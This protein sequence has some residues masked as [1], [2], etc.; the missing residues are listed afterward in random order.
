M[1]WGQSIFSEVN[2]EF[3][4]NPYPA[5]GETIAVRLRVLK[6]APVE[7]VLLRDIRDGV[8]RRRA[9]QLVHRDGMFA[10]YALDLTV[11]SPRVQYSFELKTDTGY[12]FYTRRR[13]TRF[14]QT[15][16]AD[17][18][19]LADM[20]NPDWVPGAVF[21]QIFP[22]RFRRGDHYGQHAVADGEYVFDG[23]STQA[24]Q[25]GA[26]PPEFS[27]G[28]CL[29]FFN[30]DLDGVTEAISYL[31]DLG[32]TAIYLNPIFSAKTNHRYDCIDYFSVDPHL[33]GDDAFIRLLDAL[34]REGMRCIVDVSINHT[35]KDHPWFL[36][37]SAA[38]G[39]AE[40]DFYY[41]QSDAS[42]FIYWMDIP[43]LPQ[44]NY[45]SSELRRIIWEGRDSLVRRYLDPPYSMDGWR[46]DVAN[47]V[48]RCGRDQ[49]C[50]EIWQGVRRAVKAT[51]PKAYI[52]GEHWEDHIDYVLGDQ[53][54]GAMNYFG[55]GRLLRSWMG[56]EDRFLNEAWGHSP[57]RGEVITG[58][59]LAEAITGH[60][61]RIPNQ[62]VFR[63][64]NLI[65][66]HDTPR[67]HNNSE[68][69]QWELYRGVI[70]FL[71]M[72]PGAVSYFY[73]DEVGLG[74][75]VHSV[76]GARYAM[77]WDPEKQD[78]RFLEL[79]RKMGRLKQSEKA[80][81]AGG[82]KFLY[83]DEYV[84]V[85]S[86]FY[87]ERCFVMI[88][89]RSPEARFI[90]IPVFPIGLTA[91]EELFSGERGTV[92]HGCLKVE[93]PAFRSLLYSGSVIGELQESSL[94]KSDISSGE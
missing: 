94:P 29:D 76:E 51:D 69:F 42:D 59:E 6:Q 34:H 68:V 88:L 39:S 9:M 75:H 1:N 4:S 41:R 3:V 10:T 24:L 23:H 63:E 30:G 87:R 46:F 32:V 36:A 13:V 60:L 16:D 56:E 49:F 15:E 45:G 58:T 7:Q 40:A 64:F 80:L 71:F 48:G 35:G 11:D 8:S 62:L 54:D 25:W 72:L 18:V 14:H 38:G 52:I 43:T 19:I 44:L 28:H 31:K 47:E 78:L 93:L 91:C 21:Y 17:F 66:S 50:H 90:E 70:M 74:G 81:A 20:D 73:G 2:D 65:D 83:H 5:M 37:A 84:C 79:Y 26:V 89:N 92:D 33:G 53:W 85:I 57:R 61:S 82:W 22:D 86:R 27:A 12:L 77:Q 55:S 67:L